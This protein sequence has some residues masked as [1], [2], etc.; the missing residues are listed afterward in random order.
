MRCACLDRSFPTKFWC[1]KILSHKM[2]KSK[3]KLYFICKWS[4]SVNR[5]GPKYEPYRVRMILIAK[6][7]QKDIKIRLAQSSPIWRYLLTANHCFTICYF[8]HDI[9]KKKYFK[10]KNF[11]TNFLK[12]GTFY[13][14]FIAKRD[15]FLP[16]VVLVLTQYL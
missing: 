12:T 5:A 3:R 1:T 15:K 2:S 10:V 8:F 13:E 16:L 6:L 4:I 11:R 7:W 14:R 9:N